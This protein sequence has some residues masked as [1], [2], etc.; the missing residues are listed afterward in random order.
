MAK[1][2][3]VLLAVA[4]AIVFVFFVGFGISTFYPMPKYEDYC[5]E[6]EL[7]NIQTKEACDKA[8]GKWTDTTS[9]ERPIPAKVGIPV[10]SNEFLCN[11]ID[12]RGKNITF[13][14]QTIEQIEQQGYCDLYYYCSQE[15]NKV[16]EKYNRNVFIIATGIG[17]ITLIVG[18][19]LKLASVSAGL[20]SGGVLSIIYGTI[21][22]WSDLPDYGRFIILGIALAILIWI[23]YK[24]LRK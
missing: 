22:Y 1:F 8:E 15:F 14:C 11:K 9:Y 21:R 13:N 23:G 24:K 6:K 19:A 17:I 5:K 18:F 12:E 4:I 10:S 7:V 2:K 20:M 3:Q 16:N